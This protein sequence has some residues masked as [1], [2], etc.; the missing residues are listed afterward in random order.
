MCI[1][2]WVAP[3]AYAARTSAALTS[4]RPTVIDAHITR[5]A[6]PHY[7]PSPEGI[8]GEIV[9]KLKERVGLD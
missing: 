9:E 6:L 5:L 3:F 4:G 1:V 2:T 8:I 7:A